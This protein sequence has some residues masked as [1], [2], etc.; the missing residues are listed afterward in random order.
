[1]NN[2]EFATALTGSCYLPE[3]KDMKNSSFFILH[4]SFFCTFVA[5]NYK[6]LPLLVVALLSCLS[7]MGE[8]AAE[9]TKRDF[10][11]LGLPFYETGEVRILPTAEVKFRDL[12]EAV[13]QAERYILLDY[14]KFQQ[15]SI[16]GELLARLRRKVQQGVEVRII[17]DK[18]GRASCRE[19][20]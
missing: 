4:S 11:R 9:R 19:R 3:C 13:E 12:F 10:Q 14:F 20:V 6:C 18:I 15:D 5:M 7:I 17:F 2:E 1:M 8:N 16:C